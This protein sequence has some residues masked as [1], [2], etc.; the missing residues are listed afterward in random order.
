MIHWLSFA[1]RDSPEMIRPS[2]DG[3]EILQTVF[4]CGCLDISRSVFT[5]WSHFMG[6]L[7]STLPGQDRFLTG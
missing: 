2:Q 3:K 5:F 6:D 7:P 1:P 4:L